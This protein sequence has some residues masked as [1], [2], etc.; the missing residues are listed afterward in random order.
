MSDGKED[1]IFVTVIAPSKLLWLNSTGKRQTAGSAALPP[2]T[3]VSQP[4]R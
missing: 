2:Y 4:V 3:I 1:G